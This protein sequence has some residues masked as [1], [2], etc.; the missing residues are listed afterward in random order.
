MADPRVPDALLEAVARDLRPVRPLPSPARRALALLPLAAAM[1]VVI[2]A[3]WGWRSNWSQLGVPLS[4]GLSAL[5]ALAGVAVVGLALREAVPGRAL[6]RRVLGA[7]VAAALGLVVFV[8]LLTESR[9]P[10]VVPP[11]AWLRYAWECLGMAV[12]SAVPALAVVGWLVA[13]ALPARPV[14]AGA[15]Y[16][17]GTAL[18][19]DAGVRLFCWVSTPSHVLA[20]HGG[21]ILAVAA[22]GA[23][24][25]GQVERLKS[26]RA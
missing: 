13:R 15:L 17:T 25:S 26:R 9:V 8:T 3:A 16:G 11:V 7:T 23:L 1:V 2:P 19:A 5:Q 10:T 24:V 6:S 4:W 12:V 21:A 14:L 20:A 22:A 18:I